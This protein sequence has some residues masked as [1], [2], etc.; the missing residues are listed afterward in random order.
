MWQLYCEMNRLQ[1][2]RLTDVDEG[3][4]VNLKDLLKVDAPDIK[5]SVDRVR[6]ALKTPTLWA[7]SPL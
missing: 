7:E 3:T 2:P 5:K 4:D 6:D 1:S